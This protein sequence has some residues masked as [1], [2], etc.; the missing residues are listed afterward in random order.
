MQMSEQAMLKQK[1]LMAERRMR[2]KKTNSEFKGQ[3]VINTGADGQ[4]IKEKDWSKYALTKSVS[5][6]KG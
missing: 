6:I 1:N 5:P 2:F 4:K 3:L